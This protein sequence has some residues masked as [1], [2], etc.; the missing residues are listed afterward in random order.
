MYP[1]S[2]DVRDANGNELIT[3]YAVRRPDGAWSLLLINKDPKRSF[4][5]Q[6]VSRNDSLKGNSLIK[7]PIDLYQ[8]S[9][10]QYLLGGPANNPY[11]VRAEDPA[12]KVVESLSDIT[13]PPYS[14]TVLRGALSR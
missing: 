3:T 11:P 6:V 7:A 8:Y 5:V 9:E 12:H 13:L 1:S 2:S 4:N 10:E 14:L